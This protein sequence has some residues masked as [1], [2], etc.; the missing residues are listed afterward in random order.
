MVLQYASFQVRSYCSELHL[1]WEYVEQDSILWFFLYSTFGVT[2]AL[3]FPALNCEWFLRVY[4]FYF[5]FKRTKLR[6]S[7]KAFLKI[8]VFGR[9]WDQVRI[10]HYK[11]SWMVVQK[12]AWRGKVLQSVLQWSPIPYS[13]KK[14]LSLVGTFQCYFSAEAFQWEI[15]NYSVKR[16]VK[17][18]TTF[19]KEYLVSSVGPD[20]SFVV[21]GIITWHLRSH[22]YFVQ[23]NIYLLLISVFLCVL[24]IYFFNLF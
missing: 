1:I 7:S 24:F 4:G 16:S 3:C 23:G 22:F 17:M 6:S 9:K 11:W 15:R 5:S 21:D 10:C 14:K 20:E 18:H 13:M 2:L 12:F 19:C 8:A